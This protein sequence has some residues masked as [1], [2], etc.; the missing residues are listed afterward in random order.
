MEEGYFYFLKDEYFRIFS[1]PCLMGNKEIDEQGQHAR[2]CFLAIKGEEECIYWMVPIS[3]KVEKYKR[4]YA[5]KMSK[6]R[7]CDILVFGRILGQERA[8]LIQNMCP[9]TTKYVQNIYCNGNPR[10]P[11]TVEEDLKKTIVKKA[12]KILRLERKGKNVIF[13]DVLSI[14]SKLRIEEKKKR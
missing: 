14:E 8:F 5:Y 2:P 10:V 13:P 6:F 4:I 3:S 1:D 11:V 12:A 7:S 9:V